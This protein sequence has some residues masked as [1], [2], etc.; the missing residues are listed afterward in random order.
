[1]G[2]IVALQFLDFC[3][4]KRDFWIKYFTESFASQCELTGIPGITYHGKYF[5]SNRVEGLEV[6]R[7][8]KYQGGEKLAFCFANTFS[9]ANFQIEL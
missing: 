5:L 7:R 4:Y 3:E 1:M 2:L 9:A 8:Q 6:L